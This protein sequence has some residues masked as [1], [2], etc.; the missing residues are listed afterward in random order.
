MPQSA[1]E[2]LKAPHFR[3]QT[4]TEV[5]SPCS[6]S[7]AQGSQPHHPPLLQQ[8]IVAPVHKPLQLLVQPHAE[9]GLQN[10]CIFQ[11]FFFKHVSQA[12]FRSQAPAWGGEQG[13]KRRHK[14]RKHVRAFGNAEGDPFKAASATQALDLPA[15]EIKGC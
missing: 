8:V 15:R 9:S 10:N 11:G 14:T 2:R 3:S 4:Q 5:T 1:R 13:S 12:Q 6:A 7:P